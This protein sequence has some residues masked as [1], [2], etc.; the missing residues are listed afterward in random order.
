[1]CLNSCFFLF[2]TYKLINEKEIFF[3]LFLFE[4]KILLLTK[5]IYVSLWSILFPNPINITDATLFFFF[6]LETNT[7]HKT[8]IEKVL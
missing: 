2:E 6:I 1:M 7:R 5:C 8:K 4:I 3:N